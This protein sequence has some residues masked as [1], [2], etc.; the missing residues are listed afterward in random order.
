MIV[1]TLN[2]CK[3]NSSQRFVSSVGNIEKT[4]SGQTGP[5]SIRLK[6][7]SALYIHALDLWGTKIIQQTVKKSHLL[8]EFS[9]TMH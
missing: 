2:M 5:C 8:M 3:L 9:Q 4:I 7:Y 6:Y 1:F